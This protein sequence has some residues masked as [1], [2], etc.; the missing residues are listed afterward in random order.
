MKLVAR[1]LA[2]VAAFAAFTTGVSGY[3]MAR[4]QVARSADALR[5]SQI[6]NFKSEISATPPGGAAE[7][8]LAPAYAA[9]RSREHQP[10]HDWRSSLSTLPPA[11]TFTADTPPLAPDELARLLAVRE[12]RRA[13]A[14]AP[15][16]VPHPVDQVRSASC[17]ACHGQPTRIGL[18]DVPQM[19][20]APHSQCIQC[21]APSGGPGGDAFSRP[22]VAN[23]FAGLP[24]AARG[25]RAHSEAPPT[26]PHGTHMRQNCLSCH[27]PGG[28][29]AIKTPHPQQSSCLQCHAT[30]AARETHPPL[31]LPSSSPSP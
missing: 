25:T 2:V 24:P 21:H 5:S 9:L 30:Y 27:G 13:Y 28:S 4:L 10:N 14:G 3:F 6:S 31:R 19:S 12:T 15:P 20:H 18:R 7:A 29:S 1:K 8:P 16:T 11:P 17:L 23:G 22:I 26:L